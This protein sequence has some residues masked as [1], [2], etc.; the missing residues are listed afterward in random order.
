MLMS[1]VM[2]TNMNAFGGYLVKQRSEPV[3]VMLHK[4]LLNIVGSKRIIHCR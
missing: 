1:R 2:T 4:P 3:I